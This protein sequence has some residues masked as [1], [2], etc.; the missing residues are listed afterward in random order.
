MREETIYGLPV[1]GSG[2]VDKPLA[3]PPYGHC[4]TPKAL[5]GRL[6]SCS[7]S[8]ARCKSMAELELGPPVIGHGLVDTPL[9]LSTVLVGLLGFDKVDQA[10]GGAV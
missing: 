2:L 9:A 3:S 1:I 7:T 8:G 4:S 5:A 6:S 10:A